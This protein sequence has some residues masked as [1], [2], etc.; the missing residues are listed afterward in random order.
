MWNYL[1][2][3]S[4]CN[5][6]FFTKNVLMPNL[7]CLKEQRNHDGKLFLCP[8]QRSATTQHFALLFFQLDSHFP[9]SS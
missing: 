2:K 9:T 8:P 1:V 4:V 5:D 3:I 7:F 6:V